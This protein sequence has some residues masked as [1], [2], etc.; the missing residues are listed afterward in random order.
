MSTE[1]I[2]SKYKIPMNGALVVTS[3]SSPNAVLQSLAEGSSK[4]QIPFYVI[5]D[6][7]SPTAFEL[8]GCNFMSV[9]DQKKLPYQ[10]ASLAP[11]KSY[12]RKNIGY[13][14]A[15]DN[16]CEWIC[17][18]D[19][20]NFPRD[21]FWLP[22]DRQMKGKEVVGKGWVNVYSHFA[23][24]FI[25]PR[26]FP[27]ECLSASVN[28]ELY[29]EI[30]STGIA[31]IQQGLADANP[32]VDAIYRLVHPLPLDFIKR[33]PL[34]L[35]ERAW[36]PFN[37]QN[38]TFFR[39]VFPLMYLPAHCS[40]R[41]TDIWR[42]F[43]AQ[44]LLW[45]CDWRLVFHSSTVWQER[46]EH[47]LLKDFADEIPG[48]LNNAKI[49]RTLEELPLKNGP[50]HMLTNLRQCYESLIGL[51]VVG[52]DEMPLLDAWISDIRTLEGNVR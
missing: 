23:D 17:E 12:A 22:R 43:V 41:M 14:M 31:P 26:G 45:T 39:E 40:F 27:I 34:F 11:V 2:E 32:D 44:R 25:Y 9:E 24:R 50:E 1:Q 15:I 37:S 19:D 4:H 29:D 52:S 16:G 30:P 3:I 51:G 8:D 5:G 10:Y 42:S 49:C 21:S 6:T 13:L 38:T 18:T 7:K 46:N 36:C 33:D 35:S 47:D 48:Y 20:D 28:G